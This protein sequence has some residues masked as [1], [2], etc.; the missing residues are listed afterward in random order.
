MRE[1][2]TERRRKDEF[3]VLKKTSPPVRFKGDEP[4]QEALACAKR[5]ARSLLMAA[6]EVPELACPSP[7]AADRATHS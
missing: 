6:R 4:D 7:V 1:K 5:G 2:T 3:V